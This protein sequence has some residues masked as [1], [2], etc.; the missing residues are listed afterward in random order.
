MGLNGALKTRQILHNAQGVLA[1]EGIG[2]AQALDLRDY[3]PGRG[4]RAAHA[5]VRRVVDR[6]DEDRPL[7]RDHNQMAA[8]IERCEVLEAVEAEIGKL[9]S[10]WETQPL[11]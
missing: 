7:H 10:S 5:A 3:T 2:A 1:I 11:R 6:L 8:A 4:T 9:A